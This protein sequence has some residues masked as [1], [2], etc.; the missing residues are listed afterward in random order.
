MAHQI[1]TL[2]AEQLYVNGSSASVIQTATGVSSEAGVYTLDLSAGNNFSITLS[3]TAILAAA[4]NAQPGQSGIIFIT[5]DS[6][7]NHT[8]SF[9]GSWRFSNGTIPSLSI[10]GGAVDGIAYMVRV[11]GATPIVSATLV[12]AI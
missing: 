7:G 9:D 8:M 1:T 2:L 10:T 5:Q 3:G 12:S 4:V 11:G 6:N